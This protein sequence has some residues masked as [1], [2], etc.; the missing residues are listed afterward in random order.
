MNESVILQ[1]LYGKRGTLEAVE[2]TEKYKRLLKESAEREKEL[3][4]NLKDNPE[5]LALFEK[6]DESFGAL[7]SES[8]DTYYIE[9]FKFG[10][11]MGLEIR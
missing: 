5:I 6:A 9:G 8:V 11:L 10:L 3:R 4:E 1:M 2:P 7:Y